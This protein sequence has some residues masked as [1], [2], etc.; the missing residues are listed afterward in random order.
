MRSFAGVRGE[1]SGAVPTAIVIHFRSAYDSLP[2][3]VGHITRCWSRQGVNVVDIDL[4]VEG[5]QQRLVESLATD[6]FRFA[7]LGSGAG[8]AFQ[9]NGQSFWQH[10]RVPVFFLQYD[11]PAY[12]NFVHQN[13]PSNFVL[14]YMFRDHALFQHEH[15]RAENLVTSIHFGAPDLATGDGDGGVR[16]VFP[17]TGNDPATLEESWRRLPLLAPILFDLVDEVGLGCCAAF[18][19]A[20]AK[21][22]AEHGFETQPFS[23]LSRFLLAQLDDHVR[24]RKSTMIAQALKPFPVDV[25]GRN[26]DHVAAGGTGRARFHGPAPYAVVEQAVA[27]ATATLTMNPN[28]DLSAHDRF[29]LAVGAGKVP[30]SDANRFTRENFPELAPYTFGFTPDAIAAALDR[31]FSEPQLARER[32]LAARATA[33]ARFPTEQAAQHILEC[34]R[35]ADYFEFDFKPPQ[36]FFLTGKPIGASS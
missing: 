28:I 15:V 5:W 26:W 2:G 14:G 7:L 9:E 33:R 21:I 6:D 12:R 19:P 10:R 13:L 22:T 17:K 3:I 31:V 34:A 11:H 25:Y 1:S 32:A 16:V 35:L 27:G 20:I 29:F 24:R 18:P 36:D 4:G 23:L 8:A 30:I